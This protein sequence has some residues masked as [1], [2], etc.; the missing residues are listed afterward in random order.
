MAYLL[1]M[2]LQAMMQ[3]EGIAA[4]SGARPA[5]P[6]VVGDKHGVNQSQERNNSNNRTNYGNQSVS[7]G[8]NATGSNSRQSRLPPKRKDPESKS[9]SVNHGLL[10]FFF[11]FIDP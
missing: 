8:R 3:E 1:Q 5:S 11:I 2:D 7:E 4:Q 6:A 9:S 10:V